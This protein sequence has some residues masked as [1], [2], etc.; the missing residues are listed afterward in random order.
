MIFIPTLKQLVKLFSVTI[1]TRFWNQEWP[2]NISSYP[3]SNKS[4]FYLIRNDFQ[5][6]QKVINYLGFVVGNKI[7]WQEL[8]K[9]VQSGHAGHNCRE[10]I[11]LGT[12]VLLYI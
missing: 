11:A 5:N 6:S 12:A 1:V 8:L 3:K 10:F 4:S 9:I 7:C 2:K